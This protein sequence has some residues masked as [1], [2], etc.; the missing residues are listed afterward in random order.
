[1]AALFIGVVLAFP[2]GLAGLY[3]SHVKPWFARRKAPKAA[4]AAVEPPAAPPPPPS[5]K[6]APPAALPGGVQG[7]SA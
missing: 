3:E 5:Q 2:N 4:P 1:M 7:Q 6:S